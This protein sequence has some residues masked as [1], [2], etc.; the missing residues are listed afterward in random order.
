M[1]SLRLLYLLSYSGTKSKGTFDDEES[2]KN[3]IYKQRNRQKESLLKDD[4]LKF[5]NNIK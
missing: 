5:Y 3:S 1:H 4:K 2:N